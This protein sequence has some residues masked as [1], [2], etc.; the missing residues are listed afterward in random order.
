[1]ILVP[2]LQLIFL[3]FLTPFQFMTALITIN[4]FLLASTLYFIKNTSQEKTE[5]T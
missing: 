1:M 5:Q 4:F 3:G 2:I